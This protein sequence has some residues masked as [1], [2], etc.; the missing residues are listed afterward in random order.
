M[1]NQVTQ[2]EVAKDLRLR[3]LETHFAVDLQPPGASDPVP[4]DV[5]EHPDTLRDVRVE[6]AEQLIDRRGLIRGERGRVD[7][8]LVAGEDRVG[9]ANALDEVRS[10][11]V[12]DLG[13]GRQSRR[14]VGTRSR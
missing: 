8:E 13:W 6:G 5:G 11:T 1:V 9:P 4:V 2:R 14:S 12:N 7:V 10:R 3:A